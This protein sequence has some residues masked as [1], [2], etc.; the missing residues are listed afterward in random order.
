[1]PSGLPIQI[2][3]REVISRV[4]AGE[5]TE[6]IAESLGLTASGLMHWLR[7]NAEEEWREAQIFRAMDQLEMCRRLLERALADD[8]EGYND[9]V[10][11]IV[12]SKPNVTKIVTCT[13]ITKTQIAGARELSRIAQWDLERLLRRIYG[14]QLD[15]QV[16]VSIADAMTA[17]LSRS[18]GDAASVIDAHIVS[19]STPSPRAL[20]DLQSVATAPAQPG[21]S[22]FDD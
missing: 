18:R 16:Q 12:T 13:K 1:M 17:A 9:E 5:R 8:P 3:P 2:A 4:V 11:K 15:V 7:Q 10:T 22:I 21:P 19:E 20:P 6:A 14:A